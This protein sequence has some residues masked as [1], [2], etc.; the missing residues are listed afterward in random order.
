MASRSSAVW[1]RRGSSHFSATRLPVTRCA[2]ESTAPMP[3]CPISASMRYFSPTTSPGLGIATL[4]PSSASSAF[5]DAH[6][7]AE[8]E[9]GSGSLTGW[10]QNTRPALSADGRFVAFTSEASNLVPTG[11][12]TN[13]A[14][15]VFLHDRQRRTTIRVSEDSVGTQTYGTHVDSSNPA[16]SGDGRFVAFAS[17]VSNLVPNDT[18]AVSDIYVH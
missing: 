15:D 14:K 6:D 17:I 12:D 7:R 4:V 18:N 5:I 11:R 9:R 1:P 8:P 13:G 2:A 16:I 10:S 3:P